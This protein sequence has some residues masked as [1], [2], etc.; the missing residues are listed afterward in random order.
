MSEKVRG[1]TP[2]ESAAISSVSAL[3]SNK[4]YLSSSPQGVRL[5]FSE[6]M[7]D[8]AVPNARSAVF[9]AVPDAIALRDL[10]TEHLKNYK[11][12]DEASVKKALED[13]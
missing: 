13:G 10:L 7:P 1:I 11:I 6:I 12:L 3:Y 9:L 8:V 2:E 4:I 5:T